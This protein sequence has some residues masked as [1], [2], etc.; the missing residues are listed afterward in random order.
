MNIK[1]MSD[2]RNTS[3]RN[4]VHTPLNPNCRLCHYAGY[5]NVCTFFSGGECPY[6]S[7]RKSISGERIEIKKQTSIES[8][9][10]RWT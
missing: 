8:I 10:T 5:S 4:L 7:M 1:A 2:E 6:I 3:Y 9:N